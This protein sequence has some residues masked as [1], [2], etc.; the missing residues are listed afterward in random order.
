ME[1][2]YLLIGLVFGA[3]LGAVILYFALKSSNVPRRM[4]DEINQNFIRSSSDLKNSNTKISDLENL[5]QTEKETNHQQSE[6]LKQLQNDIARMSAVNDSQNEQISRQNE[7]NSNQDQEIKSLISKNLE[8]SELKS[9]L[10]AQN[11]SLQ[12][13]LDSQKE[14]IIKLQEAAKNEFKILANEIL[15]EKTKKFTESNKENIDAILKPLGENIEN[16]RKRVNEVYENDTRE[17]SSLNSTIKLMMEQTNRVSQEANN[18]ATALKGQSK[19]QG[20]WGEMILERILED[21]GLTKDQMYF[22]QVNIKN[23]DGENFRPDFLVKIPGNK[24]VIIDSKVSLNAFERFA[25]ASEPDEQKANLQNHI[26]AIRKHIDSLGQK[27]Y[28]DIDESLDFTMMF[29]PIEPAFLLAVQE[30]SNLWNYAYSRN[31]ILTSPTNLIASLKII[32]DLWK[33]EQQSKNAM[34]IVKRG[35]LMYEKFVG[36]VG[37]MKDIGDNI[38]R[39]SRAYDKALAQLN[40]GRGNLINQALDLKSLGLKSNKEIPAQMINE[41]EGLLDFIESEENTDFNTEEID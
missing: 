29:I 41:N 23:E 31:I 27:K 36:F 9:E 25:S 24:V 3:I 16:F 4:F 30:D 5:L 14:E 8:L 35:E 34:D 11:K 15:D 20:D 40:S 2:T 28:D 21:S 38:D 1:L 19:T 37:T 17:R 12:E 32:K 7:I 13:L 18:L 6:I 10:T 39:T 26:L 33:R 22:K